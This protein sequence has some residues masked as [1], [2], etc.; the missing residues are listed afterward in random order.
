MDCA[1]MG[2]MHAGVIALTIL[3]FIVLILGAAALVKYL[4]RA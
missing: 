3:S 1:S 4:R 2:W